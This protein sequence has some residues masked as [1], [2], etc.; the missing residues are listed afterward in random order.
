M[1]ATGEKLQWMRL[2]WKSLEIVSWRAGVKGNNH[3]TRRAFSRSRALVR[4]SSFSDT[5]RSNV[6][7]SLSVKKFSRDRF[8][9]TPL[10]VAMQRQT[11]VNPRTLEHKLAEVE[12]LEALKGLN[13]SSVNQ[14][15]S[16]DNVLGC[17]SNRSGH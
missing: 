9:K 16:N 1:G 5:Y 8:K 3:G 14:R 10:S 4:S 2:E 11:L 12:H 13:S 7:K 15:E 17:T 6:D